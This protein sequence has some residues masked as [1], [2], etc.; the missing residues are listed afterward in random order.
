[1]NTN[2]HDLKTRLAQIYASTY[3]PGAY[4]VHSVYTQVCRIAF[5][6]TFNCERCSYFTSRDMS[7]HVNLCAMSKYVR[8]THNRCFQATR[9]Y[10]GPC[11][12]RTAG[13]RL[14]IWQIWRRY[15][16]SSMIK[17]IIN[18]DLANTSASSTCLR[19]KCSR[20]ARSWILSS[21]T[22]PAC[23]HAGQ[24]PHGPVCMQRT[25]RPGSGRRGGKWVKTALIAICKMKSFVYKDNHK[26]CKE[27]K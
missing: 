8:P 15:S 20:Q 14:E 3:A 7:A 16:E 17:P 22:T 12:G 1:M 13:S 4:P 6:N 19:C 26:T 9:K 23:W 5:R 21:I 2:E 10:I 24:I 18:R 25:G 11:V 27:K